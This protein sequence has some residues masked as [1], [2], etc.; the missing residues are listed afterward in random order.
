MWNFFINYLHFIPKVFPVEFYLDIPLKVHALKLN[1]KYYKQINF[2]INKAIVK[3]ISGLKRLK[4]AIYLSTIKKKSDGNFR[5][6]FLRFLSEN[7]IIFNMI[8]PRF[9]ISLT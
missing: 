4:E 2:R 6:K 1:F 9:T 8:S 3:E 7:N 5:I